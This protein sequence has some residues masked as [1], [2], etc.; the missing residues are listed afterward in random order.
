MIGRTGDILSANAPREIGETKSKYV[1]DSHATGAKP[2]V[3]HVPA[4]IPYSIPLKKMY[5]SR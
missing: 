3:T 1:A 5:I 2:Q 4:T